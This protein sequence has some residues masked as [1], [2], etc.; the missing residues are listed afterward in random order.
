[1][2]II[3]QTLRPTRN[4]RPPAA[5]GNAV[6]GALGQPLSSYQAFVRD[7]Y[8]R[9]DLIYDAIELLA[10]SAAEPRIIGRRYRNI[11]AAKRTANRLL[12]TGMPRWAIADIL[13]RQQVQEDIDERSHPLVHLLNNPNPVTSR[14]QLYSSFIMDRYLA[15]NAYMLKARGPLGNVAE[16]WRLRPDRVR[17]IPDAGNYIAGYTYTVGNETV[18]FPA[19]D[20]IHWKTRNPIDDYYGM[21]PLMPLAGHINIDN[22]MTDFI[23]AYFRQGGQPG[24]ILATKQKMRQED[25]DELRLRMRSRFNGPAGWFDTLILDQ[26]EATYTPLTQTMGARGMVMPE[27]N[28]ITEARIAAAFGIPASIFGTLVG[29]DKSSYANKKQDWQVLW[30]I[31]LAPLY[32]DLDDMLNLTLTPEFGKID[33]VLFD[34][35]Q[36]KALQEDYDKLHERARRNV[37]MGI[38]TIEEARVLTGV[39]AHAEEGTFLIPASSIPTPVGMLGVMPPPAEQTMRAL[40][41]LATPPVIEAPAAPEI[42]AEVH[43]PTCGRWVGRNLNV[44]GTAYCPKCKE[45]TVGVLT[46]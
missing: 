22:Y 35:S 30:D 8:M 36:V 9:N 27:L 4:A 3:A 1:M 32:S 7:G 43:C 39:D 26:A 19:E 44:G 29:L 40:L 6:G 28:N 20:V 42:V 45:V 38:W 10:T 13:N 2:G 24:A 34:L 21:P 25:K 31:T 11:N 18:T 37:Q 14:F 23:G 15:G 46:T 17:V 33:E 16:L 5:M 41:G 12:A